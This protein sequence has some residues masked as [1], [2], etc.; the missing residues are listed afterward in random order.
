MWRMRA[1]AG[2]IAI[3]AAVVAVAAVTLG[4]ATGATPTHTGQ[5]SATPPVPLPK[6]VSAHT[7]PA[8]HTAHPKTHPK[9]QP[10]PRHKRHPLAHTGMDLGPELLLA[11]VLLAGGLCVRAWRVRGRPRGARCA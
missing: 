3:V 11:V 4:A 9:P 6:H 7:R 1:A 10:K 5:L 2:S 8:H